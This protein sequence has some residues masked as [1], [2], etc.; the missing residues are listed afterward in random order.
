MAKM[1][2]KKKTLNNCLGEWMKEAARNP[3]WD[4]LSLVNYNVPKR[5]ADG[6]SV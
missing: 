6:D 3:K 2:E 1:K 4:S 5:T